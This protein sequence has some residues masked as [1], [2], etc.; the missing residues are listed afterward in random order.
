MREN[1][2]LSNV[3]FSASRTLL[4]RAAA[5]PSGLSGLSPS[6]LT[7]RRKNAA[8]LRSEA[9]V[10]DMEESNSAQTLNNFW[11]SGSV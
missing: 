1:L 9:C 7:I 8:K 3:R 2:V 10:R 11:K 4:S 6:S 5:T